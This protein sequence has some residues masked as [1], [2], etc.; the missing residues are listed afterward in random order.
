MD[1]LSSKKKKR[2]NLFRIIYILGT[3]V[4]IFL[5]G[6]FSNEIQEIKEILPRINLKWIG[7]SFISVILFWLS[8]ALLLGQ[9]TS[10]IYTKQKFRKSLKIGIMGLYYGALTPF[11]SGGQPMQ[12]VYMNRDGIPFGVSTAIITLKFIVY[13]LSLCFLYIVAMV[14]KGSF[15]YTNYH[16]AFWLTTVGFLLNLIAVAFISM[17]MLNRKVAENVVHGFIHF[18]SK[19]KIIR[20]EEK[21][22]A[23][24]DK[25]IDDFHVSSAYIKNNILNFLASILI[26]IFNMSFLFAIPYFIYRAFG[27]HQEPFILL[28]TLQAFL[29]LA[30]SLVPLPGAAGASEGGFYLF[31]SSMFGSIPVFM[32]MIIWRFFT[33]YLILLFGSCLVIIREFVHI[34]RS[35]RKTKKYDKN[36]V[37]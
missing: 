9:V 18:L 37:L 7:I 27:L 13:E 33:Y 29:F 26:S 16:H 28:F 34:Y 35:H 1:E 31:F 3:M 24:I 8:D 17:V 10:Y 22:T 30:V 5:I 12:V 15:F 19:I 2:Q 6:I 21:R 14:L 4:V 23:K 36:I 32:P 25:L 11:A 20:K